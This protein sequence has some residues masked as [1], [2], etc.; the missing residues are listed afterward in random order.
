MKE[1]YHNILDAIKYATSDFHIILII[2]SILFLTSLINKWADEF[3]FIKLSNI[4]MVF[5]IGYGSYISLCTVK[6]QDKPPLFVN[7]KKL[8]W[9]G[10]KKLTI[11]SIYSFF[12]SYFYGKATIYIHN[13]E[14]LLFIATVII[15]LVIWL[16]LIGGLINRFFNDGKFFSAFNLKEIVEFFLNCSLKRLLHLLIG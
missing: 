7:I 16:L 5:V 15:F 4:L 6:G 11:I 3:T 14:L 2:G 12:L 13:N 9:E 10:V 8:F 1:T